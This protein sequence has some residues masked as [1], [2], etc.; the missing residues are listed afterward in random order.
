MINYV[1][2]VVVLT[3]MPIFMFFLNVYFAIVPKIG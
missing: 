3:I 1:V 2:T